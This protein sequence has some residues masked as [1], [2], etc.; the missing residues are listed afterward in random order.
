M[1][2]NSIPKYCKKCG[3]LLGLYYLDEKVEYC[4]I[5]GNSLTKRKYMIKCPNEKWYNT[6]HSAQLLGWSDIELHNMDEI[7][8]AHFTRVL[9]TW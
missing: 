6:G 1:A 2:K 5:T 3:T 8:K 7:D 4:E 9:V